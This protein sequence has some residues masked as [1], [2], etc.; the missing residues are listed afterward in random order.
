VNCSRNPVVE[1]FCDFPRAMAFMFGQVERQLEVTDDADPS[2]CEVEWSGTEGLV[3]VVCALVS[4]VIAK[5]LLSGT[6][7][8]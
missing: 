6:R 5:V 2:H 1:V 8:P 4:G 7:M 3:V